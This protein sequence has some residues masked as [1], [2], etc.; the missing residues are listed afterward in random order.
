MRPQTFTHFADLQSLNPHQ[1]IINANLNQASFNKASKVI[2]LHKRIPP[3]HDIRPYYGDD[4]QEDLKNIYESLRPKEINNATK[5]SPIKA[6]EY[7]TIIVNCIA[8]NISASHQTLPQETL[9]ELTQAQKSLPQ[10]YP[11][12]SEALNAAIQFATE[13]PE[14]FTCFAKLR[15]TLFTMHTTSEQETPMPTPTLIQTSQECAL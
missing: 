5:H 4:L 7:Y 3:L 10:D 15:N 14:L 11:A 2:P 13:Q 8:E 1:D 12:F 9:K 6:A